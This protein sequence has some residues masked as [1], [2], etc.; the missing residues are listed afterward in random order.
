MSKRTKMLPPTFVDLLKSRV[1]ENPNKR[2]ITYLVDG[3]EEES[4]LTYHELDSKRERLGQHFKISQCQ[5]IVFFSSIHQDWNIS[6]PLWDVCTRV[7]LLYPLIL[8][9]RSE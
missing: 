9:T 3:E 7:L 1:Q 5:D 4:H 6:K 8:R 2:V